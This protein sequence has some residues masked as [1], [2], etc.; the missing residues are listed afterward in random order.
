MNRIMASFFGRGG[1]ATEPVVVVDLAKRFRVLG[2]ALEMFLADRAEWR[3]KNF[4]L[5]D[6]HMQPTG[7]T[8][9]EHAEKWRADWEW[10]RE[11]DKL[12]A[13]KLQAWRELHANDPRPAPLQPAHP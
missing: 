2:Q 4:M 3:T 10:Q 13:A 6:E 11:F 8:S 12:S 7:R 9:F 5:V 1:S